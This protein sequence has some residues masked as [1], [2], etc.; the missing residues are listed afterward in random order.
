MLEEQDPHLAHDQ[1]CCNLRTL[2]ALKTC[3]QQIALQLLIISS[4]YKSRL[5]PLA[6]AH[7]YDVP[8]EMRKPIPGAVRQGQK[9]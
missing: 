6:L 7:I 8:K 3:E 4:I 1:Q 2:S 5:R 9:S